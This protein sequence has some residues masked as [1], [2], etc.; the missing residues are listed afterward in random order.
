MSGLLHV[1]C[2]I[3]TERRIPSPSPFRVK[4][5]LILE[6]HKANEVLLFF[7]EGFFFGGWRGCINCQRAD[8]QRGQRLNI[9]LRGLTVSS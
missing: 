2:L 4:L 5:L 8:P 1:L 7:Q 6:K 9:A 3:R